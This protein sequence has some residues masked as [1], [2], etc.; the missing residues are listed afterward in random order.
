MSLIA[1]NMDGESSSYEAEG[2]AHPTTPPALAEASV[3]VEAISSSR[4]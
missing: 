2:P 1:I 3:T 4:S